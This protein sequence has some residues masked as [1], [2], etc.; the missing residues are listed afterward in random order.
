MTSFK[1]SCTPL[2]ISTGT[3]IC[4]RSV[5]TYQ[6]LAAH[7]STLYLGQALLSWNIDIFCFIPLSFIG[8][9]HHEPLYHR[10]L[11]DTQINLC[12][13]LSLD[14]V[15]TVIQASTHEYSSTP[16]SPIRHSLYPSHDLDPTSLGLPAAHVIAH[17]GIL[18]MQTL[19]CI[20][21]LP[22]VQVDTHSSCTMLRRTRLVQVFLLGPV[23]SSLMSCQSSNP[24]LSQEIIQVLANDTTGALGTNA[25]GEM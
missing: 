16:L 17:L 23:L 3:G 24:S 10:N 9:Q 7:I 14:V 25:G 11:P 20:V 22:A 15:V 13:G 6:L 18:S 19:P 21:T 1:S 8:A 5:F 2:S 12:H 4:C